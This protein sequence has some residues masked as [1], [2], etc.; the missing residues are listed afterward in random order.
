MLL[1]WN[2]RKR[3]VMP[4]YIWYLQVSCDHHVV[5]KSVSRQLLLVCNFAK[6]LKSKAFDL[7]LWFSTI[8]DTTISQNC[9]IYIVSTHGLNSVPSCT[10]KRWQI[11]HNKS[12]SRVS[13]YQRPTGFKC[14]KTNSFWRF[15]L[16][17]T[18]WTKLCMSW[19]SVIFKV[20]D[21]LL[22]FCQS[23]FQSTFFPP[24]SFCRWKP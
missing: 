3:R 13:T 22:C 10:T 14:L 12:V 24:T 6:F 19:L 15:E 1:T 2:V 16:M 7:M 5:S 8:K 18:Y 9:M 21:S 11:K 4:S 17:S 23:Q 20:S